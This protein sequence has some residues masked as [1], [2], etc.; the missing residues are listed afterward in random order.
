V[1]GFPLAT[2]E[3]GQVFDVKPG[4][5]IYLFALRCAQHIAE[6]S[7]AT[8]AAQPPLTKSQSQ[9]NSILPR[10]WGLV[11]LVCA[12]LPV[13]YMCLAGRGYRSH[14]PAAAAAGQP[15]HPLAAAPLAQ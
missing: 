7:P 2:L 8:I 13:W 12:A 4:V 14:L 1:G 3:A 11:A 6:N 15:R 10:Q 9:P 5:G